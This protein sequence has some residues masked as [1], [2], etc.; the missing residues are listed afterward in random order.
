M[1]PFYTDDEAM[2]ILELFESVPDKYGIS[3]PRLEDVS[4]V[5][6]TKI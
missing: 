1:K 5:R 6:F 3:I 2:L 4:K